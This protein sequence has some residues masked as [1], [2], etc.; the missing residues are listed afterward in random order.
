MLRLLSSRERRRL[1]VDLMEENPQ[2]DR[3]SL[4]EDE[5]L[6]ENEREA[7]QSQFVHVHLPKL[8]AAGYI[9]W[10]RESHEIVKGPKFDEIRPLLELIH[11]HRDELPD[12]WI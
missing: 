8:E 4:P 2:E 5:V 7:L 12:G 3:V 1:L 11:E 9:R 6:R 10:D